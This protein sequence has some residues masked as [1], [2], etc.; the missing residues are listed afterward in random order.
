MMISDFSKARLLE[1]EK[2]LTALADDVKMTAST[3]LVAL[4]GGLVGGQQS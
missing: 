4:S 1:G 3:I 2:L